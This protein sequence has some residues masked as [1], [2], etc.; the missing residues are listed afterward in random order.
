VFFVICLPTASERPFVFF[1]CARVWPAFLISMIIISTLSSRGSC[2]YYGTRSSFS[3][4]LLELCECTDSS[5]DSC[6]IL[7][8]IVRSM[9]SSRTSPSSFSSTLPSILRFTQLMQKPSL[10]LDLITGRPRSPSI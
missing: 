7:L 5:R 9:K 3:I 2:S 6:V 1:L 4:C 10:G 8:W